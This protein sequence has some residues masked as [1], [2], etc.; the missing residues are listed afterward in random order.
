MQLEVGAMVRGLLTRYALG[1]DLVVH[2]SE[3]AGLHNSMS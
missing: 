3:L 1:T 2:I